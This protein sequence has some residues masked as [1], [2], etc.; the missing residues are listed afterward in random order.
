[1][2]SDSNQEFIEKFEKFEKEYLKNPDSE[3]IASEYLDILF[4][5]ASKSI[6]RY[7][8]ADRRAHV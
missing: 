1:M 5:L 4:D 2:N 8:L 7:S 3:E 6:S